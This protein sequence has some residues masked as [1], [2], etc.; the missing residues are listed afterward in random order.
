MKNPVVH[1][2]DI[3]LPAPNVDMQKWSVVAVDQYT[4]EPEYWRAAED[5]VGTAPSALKLVLPE[6]Y[7]AESAARIPQMHEAMR[8]Y[9]KAGTLAERVRGGYLLVERRTQSGS[10]LGLMACLDLEEYDYAAGS[11]SL[12]RATEGTVLERV[13]PRVALRRGAAIELPHILMLMDDPQRRVIEPLHAQRDRLEK[14]YD[15]ELM[16]GGGHLTGWR[17]DSATARMVEDALD[18]VYADCDGLFLAVGDGNHSLAAARARWLEIREALPLEARANHPARYALAE[19]EN[20]HSQAIAFA[21]IHR[22][23][24]GVNPRALAR[25]CA[26]ALDAAGLRSGDAGSLTLTSAGM[27]ER[28][29][30]DRHPL[31]ALQ[32]F[33]DSYL[34]DHPEA[35]IDY[36]H[37]DETLR[38]LSNRADAL[39][40]MPCAFAKADLFP[41]IRRW[42]VLPRKTFSMGQANEKRFYLEARRIEI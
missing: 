3:L 19:I 27:E 25:A 32:N 8:A 24:T 4:S 16:Q 30:F 1:P 21:P 17:V 7:L 18:A 23:L 37:G 2:A 39:G 26:E 10:R 38:R 20:L 33:L 6:A 22:L 13:P 15:F 34:I 5:L 11:Q 14:L 36:I 41:Y 35:K 28:F 40:L 9:L 31:G 12:I 42:G 29:R